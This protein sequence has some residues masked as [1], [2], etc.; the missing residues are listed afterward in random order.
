ME[1]AK[2]CMLQNI[3][4]MGEVQPI[5]VQFW[6]DGDS[7]FKERVRDQ[8]A[9]INRFISTRSTE[10]GCKSV[11]GILNETDWIEGLLRYIRPQNDWYVDDIPVFSKADSDLWLKRICEASPQGI[12]DF[13]HWLSLLYPEDMVRESYE[14]DAPIIKKM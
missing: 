11:T 7:E 12:Y 6:D 3:D 2:E 9:E 14:R 1:I 8:V 10:A 4:S 5:V 13:Q